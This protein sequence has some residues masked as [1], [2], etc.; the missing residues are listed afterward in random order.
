MATSGSSTSFPGGEIGTINPHTSHITVFPPLTTGFQPTNITRGPQGDQNLWFT[1]QSG[2][3][4]KMDS[5]TGHVTYFSVPSLPEDIT[6]SQGFLWFTDATANAI[7]RMSL[8]GAVTEFTL[9]GKTNVGLQGIT[10]GLQ[11][12][13]WFT[14]AGASK[15]GNV[16]TA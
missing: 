14:E 5:R 7:D 15:I 2:Q 13:I 1:E 8:T 12:K 11:N 9:P 4:G 10:V 6:T 3:I 16:T